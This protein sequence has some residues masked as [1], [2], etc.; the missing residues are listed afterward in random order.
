MV[1]IFLVNFLRYCQKR[2]FIFFKKTQNTN[3]FIQQ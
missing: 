1:F 2:T 3:T